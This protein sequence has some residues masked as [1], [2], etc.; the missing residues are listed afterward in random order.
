[1]NKKLSIQLTLSSLI[2]LI[3]LSF[4]L[5][6]FNKKE[7][8]IETK[9]IS[10]LNKNN[11]IQDLQYFSRDIDGNTYLLIAES[12]TADI[13]NS[14]LIYL[15]DVNAKINFDKNKEVLIS[16]DKAIYNNNTYDTEFIGNVIVNYEKHKLSS[17]KMS[18]LL[19]KDIAVLSGG[20]TYDNGFTQLYADK[21]DFDLNTRN[22][23]ISMYNKGEKVKIKHKEENGFN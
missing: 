3:L 6:F 1:M 15:N 2:F 4:Y 9:E 14:D 16:S 12:G 17:E 11:L 22:S 20:V 21:I 23:K 13:E 19:S 10:E 7:I 8:R 5:N 18:A